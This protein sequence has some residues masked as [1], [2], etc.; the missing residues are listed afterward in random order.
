MSDLIKYNSINNHYLTKEI[1]WAKEYYGDI[2]E[3]TLWSVTEKIHG[4]NIS[5]LISPDKPIRHFSRN[6]EIIGNSFMNSEENLKYIDKRLF[7]LQNYCD[8]YK[9]T[10][11]LFGEFFGPGIQKGVDY[12]TKKRILFF[13]MMRNDKFLSQLRINNF[14][15]NHSLQDYYVKTLNIFESF[16][17]AVNSNI[18]FDS[19]YN[20]IEDNK[21]E[22]IVIKPWDYV[23]FDGHGVP[24]Y[25]K[26]KNDKFLEKIQKKKRKEKNVRPVV[27]EW[28]ETFISYIH[29]DRL[30]SVFSKEG[31]IESIKE[32]GNFIPLI[33]L[34]VSDTFYK[35]E[36]FPVTEFNKDEH[37]YIFNG[38]KEIVQLLK[39]ELG[40][41]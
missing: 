29:K 11:R 34:D 19:T 37:K 32:L 38:S 5:F 36:D 33:M 31:R 16:D 1:A 4:C 21:I 14:V 10:L 12:G 20:T 7:P 40:M 30:E 22:G 17:D 13:D 2:F 23:L 9:V 26:K 3:K 28:H 41:K 27:H 6:Q 25:L 8:Y 18:D 35:E 15:V 39:E 24:F